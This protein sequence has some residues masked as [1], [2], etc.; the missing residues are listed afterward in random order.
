MV[1]GLF[2]AG[3]K[4]RREYVKHLIDPHAPSMPENTDKEDTVKILVH[5]NSPI[6]HGQM[7]AERDGGKKEL[8]QETLRE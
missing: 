8:E 1:R 4:K 5:I 2:A 6:S 3:F 7:E